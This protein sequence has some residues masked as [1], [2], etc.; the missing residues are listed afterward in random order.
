MRG[1]VAVLGAI[2]FIIAGGLAQPQ[3]KNFNDWAPDWA[4]DG[5]K[6]VFVSDRDGNSEIYVLTLAPVT[7]LKRL[8]E[9]RASDLGP[10]FSPD[11]TKIVFYSSRDGN[12]EIYLMDADGSTVT[13]LTHT[14]AIDWDPNWTPD[15]KIIFESFRDGWPDLYLIDP[16]TGA[17]ERLTQD[18]WREAFPAWSPKNEKIVFAS[19]REGSWNLYAMRPNGLVRQKLTDG[20]GIYRH[21]SWSRDGRFIVLEAVHGDESDIARL[22][23]DGQNFTWL[24]RDISRDSYPSLAPHGKRIVY[25][26]ERAGYQRLVIRD[27]SP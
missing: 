17:L 20:N 14:I 23:A 26:S 25:T 24:T 2:F 6:I 10:R 15:G 11:G 12:Y 1:L 13:R 16:L 5:T 27:V 19:Y 3:P 22:D 18:P 9:H 21:P 4:P 7:D 8:T